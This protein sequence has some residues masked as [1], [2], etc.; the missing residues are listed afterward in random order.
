[1][2]FEIGQRIRIVRINEHALRPD[3]LVGDTG[4]IERILED[5]L[6]NVRLDP[7]AGEINGT[8]LVYFDEMEVI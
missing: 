7:P 8:D 6:A 2:T 4:T 5:D 1:M 3:F